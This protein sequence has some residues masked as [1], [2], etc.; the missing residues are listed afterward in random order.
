LRRQLGGLVAG[1]LGLWVVL[2]YPGYLFG[3]DRA[4]VYSAIAAILCLLPTAGTLLWAGWA[5]K[6]SPEQQLLMVLGGS[7]V[8]MAV[9]LGAGL[10]LYSWVAYFQQR[11]FW[12]WVLVFYLVTLALEMT[13][14]LGYR[15]AVE[16][17]LDHQGKPI[18][19]QKV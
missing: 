4:V 8:R 1:V 18:S 16:S 6:Q 11:S 15:S 7:G 2:V 3:G 9:V 19:S 5:F 13:L 17:T 12:Y 10:V 14:L